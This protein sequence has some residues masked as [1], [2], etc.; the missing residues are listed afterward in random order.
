LRLG[1]RSAD[2]DLRGQTPNSTLDLGDGSGAISFGLRL[3]LALARPFEEHIALGL[4]FNTPGAAIARVRI[5]APERPQ[6]PL[7]ATRAESLD[8]AFGLGVSLPLSI[9]VGAGVMAQASV[10]GTVALE[11]GAS[12]TV[13]SH[14]DDELRLVTAPLVGFA[15]G[16][17]P[18][19]LG[20]AYRGELKS[21]FDL[22]VTLEDLGRVV[23]PPLSVTGLGQYDPEQF[24]A[25]VAYTSS[26]YD[27]RLGVSY[28]RWS[29]IER[30]K[31]PTI[32]C[33]EGLDDCEQPIEPALGFDDTWVPRAAVTRTFALTENSALALSLGYFYEPSPLPAQH[34]ATNLWDNP[35]HV[36]SFGTRVH[37]A[38]PELDVV[39]G[40]QRHFLTP[41]R[42]DKAGVEDSP[43]P[44]V[45]TS[46][47]IWVSSVD[48]EVPF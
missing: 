9:R 22:E 30:L 38:A 2:F 17:P 20:L 5:L 40:V 33:P 39:F 23:L 8:F 19:S 37:L 6:F 36:A 29:G 4:D 48:L 41:R 26:T 32:V 13:Q 21:E 11:A 35:R 27:V 34:G 12:S 18:L 43:F 3:P 14:V 46:G 1:Y 45:D 47:S 31:G 15:L 42:H 10:A 44:W 7:L 28:K 16:G 25:E 24:Q